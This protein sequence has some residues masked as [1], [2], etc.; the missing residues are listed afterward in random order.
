MLIII[1][2]RADNFAANA[3]SPYVFY[4]KS[5]IMPDLSGNQPLP[6]TSAQAPDVIAPTATS[7]ADNTTS[8]PAPAPT[9]ALACGLP[10]YDLQKPGAFY[11]DSNGGIGNVTA[12]SVLCHARSCGSYAYGS[13]TCML[14]AAPVAGNFGS[15]SASPYVFYDA[16][17]A[18]GAV[19]NPFT[20]SSS[21]TSKPTPTPTPITSSSSTSSTSKTSTSSA[22]TVIAS[23]V[24]H[25]RIEGKT[26][27]LFEGDVLD[28]PMN[29][30]T[31]RGGTHMCDSTNGGANLNPGPTCTAPLAIA[32]ASEGFAIDGDYDTALSDFT[33]TSIAGENSTATQKWGLFHNYQTVTT[34]CR[35]QVKAGDQILWAFDGA[36]AKE[37]LKL[38]GPSEIVESGAAFNVT[39]TDLIKGGPVFN[40]SV[41]DISTDRNGIATLSLDYSATLKATKAGAIRSNGIEVKVYEIVDDQRRAKPSKPV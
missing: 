29:V 35:R 13:N 16:A 40:A 27:T 18:P 15:S 7:R 17:C 12:C 5:C 33:I 26:D 23:A 11:F 14:Y 1:G 24:V 9:G 28:T 41:E 22:P 30:T 21:S 39:V 20:T 6:V 37:I 38:T 4:D 8:S 32:A 10:G 19:V 36:N 25:L 31:A 34:G 2:N 3:K